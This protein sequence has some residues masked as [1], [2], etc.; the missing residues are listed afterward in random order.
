MNHDRTGGVWIGLYPKVRNVALFI[1]RYI[2]VFVLF[3]LASTLQ[4]LDHYIPGYERS[5]HL[6]LVVIMGIGLAVWV[7][8]RL[9]NSLGN[10]YILHFRVEKGMEE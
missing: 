5:T 2:G 7:V 3:G 1:R 10:R 9:F 6:P 8:Y 4:D